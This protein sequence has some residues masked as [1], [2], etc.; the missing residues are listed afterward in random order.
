MSNYTPSANF[1]GG[2]IRATYYIEPRQGGFRI[3]RSGVTLSAGSVAAWSRATLNPGNLVAPAFGQNIDYVMSANFGTSYTLT[4]RFNIAGTTQFGTFAT[5]TISGLFCLAPP[6]VPGAPSISSIGRGLGQLHINYS[7]NNGGSAI[8]NYEYSLNGGGA[9]SFGSTSNPLT[10]RS[11]NNG[12]SYN[13]SIRAIN[14]VGTGAWSNT[15]GQT[16]A[17]VPGA[18]T[19]NSLTIG[20][21]NLRVNYTAPDNGGLSI[22]NYEYSLNGGGA[23]SF[24][25]TA[26]PLTIGSLNNGT[27]Y[28]VSI[29]AINAV[30]TGSWSN[31]VSQTP[32]TTPNQPANLSVTNGNGQVTVSFTLPSD[33]GGSAITNYQYSTNNG[34]TFTSFSPSVTISPVTITGLTNGTSYQIVLRAVNGLGNGSSSSAIT[35]T[36]VTTP[37]QP[38]NLSVTNGNGQVSVSFTLPSSNGGSSIINYQYS[39]DNGSTFTSFS[40]PVTTSPVTITGLTNG[41]SY[42]IVLRAVN[43][44]GNGLSSSAITGT[45]LTTPNQPTNLSITN[46]NGQVSVSFTLPSSNGGSAITNYQYSIDNGSTFASFS[47]PITTSPATIT[48]LTNGTSYSIILR[49]VNGVGNGLSSSVVTGV[50]VTI[51]NQPTNLSITN[52]N[53]QVSVSFTSPSSNGGSAITNYQYSI[54]NGSTFASFSPPVTTSPVTITGLANG[55]SY[56]I[57][58]RAVN[59]VGNGSFS[60]AITGT[61]VSTPTQPT[62]LSVTNGIGEVSVSFTLPSSN[63]GS[64]IIN[65]QYSIDNGSTFTPFSPPV[66]TSPVIITGL[67]NGTSYQ[68]VLRA[69]NGVGNGLS[70]SAITGS[71]KNPTPPNQPTNLSTLNGIGQIIVYFTDPTDNGGSAITNYQYSIDNGSTFVS[72]SPPVTTSPVTIT[73]LTN[74]TSY[75]IILRAMNGIGNG[76]SSIVVTGTSGKISMSKIQNVFGGNN[77][78]SFSEYYSN[79]SKGYTTGISGIPTIGIPLK[80]RNFSG[81]SKGPG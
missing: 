65:Y 37:N 43:G 58:L 64:S 53:G 71:P 48:G 51:P 14:A 7:V 76:S 44:V 33:N 3:V 80:F 1:T 20:D 4:E 45:P 57:L 18:P 6:T 52:G 75:Q 47:P 39:I 16:T 27:S 13:V 28:N 54:D 63:G 12:T 25:S 81:K 22:T 59:G 11:L 69:L 61:P 42:Q 19:I 40:P 68:I 8:T 56:Q 17:S 23:V 26:N 24:G 50:P 35:G 46:G 74:G 5:L 21:R 62:N 77:P 29:R 36:P 10:I 2:N 38:T 70:S 9:V 60:S 73:G 67:A 32:A 72:F 49:A 15:V 41:T 66:I 79:S 30:G 34:S 55:T 31:T 78:I